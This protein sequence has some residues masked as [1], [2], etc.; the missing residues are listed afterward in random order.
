[1]FA[2]SIPVGYNPG[3]Y[4]HALPASHKPGEAMYYSQFYLAPVSSPPAGQEGERSTY[5]P[6]FFPATFMTAYAQPY[7]P[8]IV[9][10]RPDAQMHYTG[11]PDAG[12]AAANVE[13]SGAD[14]EEGDISDVPPD[15]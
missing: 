9:N 1:M 5:P 12:S 14:D 10:S 8:Y 13:P 7:P 2:G 11:A 3:F 4:A 15:D 6:Q